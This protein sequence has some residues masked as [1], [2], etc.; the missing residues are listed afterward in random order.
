VFDSKALF[1]TG[2]LVALSVFAVSCRHVEEGSFG[3]T[4][5]NSDADTDADSDADGDTDSD[6]DPACPGFIGEGCEEDTGAPLPLLVT[7][8]ELGVDRFVGVAHSVLLA[9]R[10]PASDTTVNDGIAAFFGDPTTYPE[11]VWEPVAI[12]DL[13][14]ALQPISIV[15]GDIANG[16]YGVTVLFCDRGDGVC[17][18]LRAVQGE[19]ANTTAL[20]VL[21]EGEVPTGGDLR[22]ANYFPSFPGFDSAVVCAF[23]DGIFCFD[24]TAWTTEI[25]PGAGPP[26]NDMDCDR[27]GDNYCT[28]FAA[29]GD[30]GRRAYDNPEYDE[31][32]DGFADT[33]EDL[34]ALSGAGL[35][36]G[37]TGGVLENDAVCTVA[38]S[39]VV[40]LYG[41]WFELPG[42]TPP[43]TP[44]AIPFVGITEDRRLFFGSYSGFDGPHFSPLCP[45][46]LDPDGPEVGKALSVGYFF[47][48]VSYNRLALTEQALYGTL[49]C[50]V[51]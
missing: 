22:G 46:A 41:H 4:D 21:P 14:D 34:L 15:A 35:V 9:A 31:W 44:V 51:D 48:G 11:A 29:V 37:G 43:D 18:L 5:S 13:V 32:V 45:G 2:G 49:E 12:P 38:D 28:M 26:F 40:G 3:D 1:M 23:G 8:E 30:D 27:N 19:W 16:P 6:T 36:A 10:F 50:G 47:C 20:E 39:P 17:G 24:G 25:P 7:A 33:S 42:E